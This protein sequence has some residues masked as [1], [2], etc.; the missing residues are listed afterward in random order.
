MT[1]EFLES[2]ILHSRGSM[3]YY[4]SNV[5]SGLSIIEYVVNYILNI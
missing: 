2:R 3:F 1:I 5:S 4:W